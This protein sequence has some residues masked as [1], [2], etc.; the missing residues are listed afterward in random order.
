MEMKD[1]Y[2]FRSKLLA[3][4]FQMTAIGL[5]HDSHGFSHHHNLILA[6]YEGINFP[7]LFKQTTGKKFTDILTSGWPNLLLISDNCKNILTENQVKGWT[8]YPIIL[9]DKKDNQIE[10]YHGFSVTGISG[11]KSYTNSPI[12]E[13]SYVAEGPIVRIYKGA[14]I[15]LSKWDGSDFFVP[16]GT[17]GIV[18]TKK[19]AELLKRNKISNLS[20][21]CITE[22]EFDVETWDKLEEKWQLEK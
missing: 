18:V 16:E 6:K 3:S 2:T 19:V 17:G 13:T 10:G 15:D 9:K 8:T 21:D 1:L 11:R 5:G 14:T 20:L 12:I 22:G 4:S 7:V